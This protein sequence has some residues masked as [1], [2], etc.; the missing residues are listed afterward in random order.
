MFLPARKP[1]DTSF[2]DVLARNLLFSRNAHNCLIL[3][4]TFV[5]LKALLTP[6][7]AEPTHPT[8]PP[9]N[10]ILILADDLGWGDVGFNGRKDWKTP[11]LDRLA[12]QGTVFKRFYAA[13]TTCGPSRATLMTGRY[14]IHN[15]V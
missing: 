1:N 10:I 12:K 2:R 5:C 4:L 15:G 14:G 11:N 3:L 8:S 9:P 7:P 13:G 6:A